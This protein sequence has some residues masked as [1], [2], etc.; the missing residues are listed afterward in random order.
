M[1]Y[2]AVYNDSGRM[3]YLAEPILIDG[4][5]MLLL[6]GDLLNDGMRARL[7]LFTKDGFLPLAP[8]QSFDPNFTYR[9]TGCRQFCGRSVFIPG[10]QTAP[11]QKGKVLVFD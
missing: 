3:T 10:G 11:S 7:F 4:S 2:A 9:Q 1:A 6:S 5:A 8:R